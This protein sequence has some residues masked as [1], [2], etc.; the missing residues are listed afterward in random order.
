ML[1]I[2][3]SVG[4]DVKTLQQN[5]NTIG[6]TADVDGVYGANTE[7]AVRTF[8]T[9]NGI[10]SDGKYGP[11]TDAKMQELLASAPKAD[12]DARRL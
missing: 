7:R 9:A 8:Q 6:V 3:G 11:N 4:P 1:L 2:R 12:T 5:L 10:D